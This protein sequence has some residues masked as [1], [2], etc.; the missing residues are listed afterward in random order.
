MATTIGQ[1]VVVKTQAGY[2]PGIITGSFT[3]S[4][5]TYTAKSDVVYSDTAV[6]AADILLLGVDPARLRLSKTAAGTEGAVTPAQIDSM[7][8]NTWGVV[9]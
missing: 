7:A 2:V 6:D 9:T 4:G 5:S 1:V 8:V 3:V